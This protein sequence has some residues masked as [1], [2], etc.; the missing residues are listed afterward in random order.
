MRYVERNP[1][2]ARLVDKAADYIWSSAAAHCGREKDTILSPEFPPP[3]QISTEHTEY[4]EVK[5]RQETRPKKDIE[6][7]KGILSLIFR[8]F[9]VFRG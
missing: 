4:T 7:A 2:R 6:N 1:V 5:R 8:V 3:E 9:R